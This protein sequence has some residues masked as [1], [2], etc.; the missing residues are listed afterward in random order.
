MV[1][2]CTKHGSVSHAKVYMAV[3]LRI[4]FTRFKKW[5]KRF[6]HLKTR[7]ER[8]VIWLGEHTEQQIVSKIE[9]L[10]IQNEPPKNGEYRCQTCP[11]ALL[12]KK[13]F[14]IENCGAAGSYI[15]SS[16]GFQTLPQHVVKL[17][18]KLD[19]PV[20]PFLGKNGGWGFVS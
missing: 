9:E 10:G 12:G 11:I 8:Y 3:Y 14:R 19:H 5:L 16:D 7:L 20:H 4:S 1:Q 13:L 2:Y 18:L 6:L 15:T 17:I